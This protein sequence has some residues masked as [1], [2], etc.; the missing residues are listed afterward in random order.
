MPVMRCQEDGVQ[1]YKWGEEGH[2]YTY[3]Q[4]TDR[5]EAEAKLAAYEQGLA[6]AGEEIQSNYSYVQKS[7][8]E[9]LNYT[10]GIVYT[11][12]EVDLQGEYADEKV[13]RKAMWDYMKKVQNK[14]DIE[15]IAMSIY[16][17]FIK[18]VNGEADEVRIDVSDMDVSLKKNLGDMHEDIDSSHGT[19]VECYQA[20]TDFELNGE[21]IKKGT[22]LLGVVW[23]DE[24][25][26]KILSGERSGYSMGG[27]GI[28]I[29]TEEV[30]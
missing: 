29:E 15:K 4:G 18:V 1:G 19:I 24:M 27:R 14:S 21:E 10:L 12:D 17:S 3:G 6:I 28:A 7:V 16:D 11:P 8:D 25:F 23:S 5:S 2:C 22:W 20:P 26:Q 13:I 30:N 9:H